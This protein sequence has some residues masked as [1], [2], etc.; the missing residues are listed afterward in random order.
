ML[1][2]YP[3]SILEVANW[4]CYFAIKWQNDICNFAIKWNN[5]RQTPKISHACISKAALYVSSL[6]DL[7]TLS[8]IWTL[9]S[10]KVVGIFLL[11]C[12]AL[13]D[14][15][16]PFLLIGSRSTC[17]ELSTSFN[18]STSFSTFSIYWFRQK[19]KKYLYSLAKIRLSI[20]WQQY[21]VVKRN[22]SSLNQHLLI[23]TCTCKQCNLTQWF[24]IILC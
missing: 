10:A 20:K 18:C 4:H 3:D 12:N 16:F 8:L 22:I 14:K 15:Y 19:V 21:T 1:F 2:S 7:A 6:R 11:C 5:D 24:V 13:S 17:I 9:L 23:Y